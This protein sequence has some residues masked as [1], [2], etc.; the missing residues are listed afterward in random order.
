MCHPNS[1]YTNISNW[2][3]VQ[4]H[5]LSKFEDHTYVNLLQRPDIKLGKT[6]LSDELSLFYFSFIVRNKT[7]ISI[8]KQC[9]VILHLSINDKDLNV[10]SINVHLFQNG[11]YLQ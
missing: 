6:G 3:Y 2:V 11:Y 1:E 4:F 5:E 8:N 9:Y 7:Y 10:V